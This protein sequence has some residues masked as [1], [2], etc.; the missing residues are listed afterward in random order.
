ME[1]II[2]EQAT[3]KNPTQDIWSPI[4]LEKESAWTQSINWEKIMESSIMKYQVMQSLFSYKGRRNRRVFCI[5]WIM[6]WLISLT[7]WIIGAYLTNSYSNEIMKAIVMITSRILNI[8][9]LIVEIMNIIK[10]FHDQGKPWSDILW[11]LIPIYNIVVIGKL[12]FKPWDNENNM[13]TESKQGY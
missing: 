8:L 10:R 13:Y 6:G 11:L 9:I 2:A 3:E 1:E 4:I 5:Y 12:V 7:I